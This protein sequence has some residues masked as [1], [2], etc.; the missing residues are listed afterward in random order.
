MLLSTLG[1]DAGLW[2]RTYPLIREPAA[3]KKSQM[4]LPART[5]GP[6]AGFRSVAVSLRLTFSSFS[7]QEPLSRYSSQE[8]ALEPP[9]LLVD[10]HRTTSGLLERQRFRSDASGLTSTFSATDPSPLGKPIEN[11]AFHRNEWPRRHLPMC[12]LRSA[13]PSVCKERITAFP[14]CPD[15]V[16]LCKRRRV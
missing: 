1:K 12:R 3:H 15:F 6:R 11:H 7:A 5:N 13:E 16:W 2:C 10:E 8:A 14:L 9:A 4:L